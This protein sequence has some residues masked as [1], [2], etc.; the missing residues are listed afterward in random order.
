MWKDRAHTWQ[1]AQFSQDFV[2]CF[3]GVEHD[4]CGVVMESEAMTQ[5]NDCGQRILDI[6]VWAAPENI[7]ISLY[8]TKFS[9]YPKFMSLKLI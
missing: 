7:C 6:R 9:E 3:D 2:R 4:S 8:A 1:A 5:R